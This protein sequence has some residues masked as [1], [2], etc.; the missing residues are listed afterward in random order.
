MNNQPL[1]P[2]PLDVGAMALN[3]RHI[4]EASAGTGKTY[5]ITRIFIRLLLVK[6]VE[7]QQILVVTFTKAATEELR[8]R[9][10]EAVNELLTCITETPD[11]IDDQFRQIIEQIPIDEE[12]DDQQRAQLK[13]A[14]VL[15]KS[16]ALDLDEASVFTIH[17]FCQRVIKQTAF[18]RHQSFTPEVIH[19]SRAY[20]LQE[21]QDWFRRHQ[22]E[23]PIVSQ[24][25]QLG[26]LTPNQFVE[27]FY[28]ALIGYNT[29]SVMDIARCSAESESVAIKQQKDLALANLND[30]YQTFF[31]HPQVTTAIT[32]LQTQIASMQATLSAEKADRIAAFEALMDWLALP[33]YDNLVAKTKVK[34]IFGKKLV[35]RFV[36]HFS[37]NTDAKDDLAAFADKYATLSDEAK[38]LCS[39]LKKFDT[40]LA[41]L[42]KKQQENIQFEAL[43]QEVLTWILDIRGR[44]LSNKQQ[45]EVIDHDDTIHSLAEAISQGNQ[46]LINYI[47]THYPFA[48]IDEFQDTDKH[49]YAIFSHCYPQDAT[50]TMLVMIGDPKQAIYGFRGG[51]INTYILAREGAQL[52]SMQHN[53]RSSDAV[54]NGYNCLFYG[55]KVTENSI[56]DIKNR[57]PLAQHDQRLEQKVEADRDSI[58]QDAHIFDPH[59]PY[60]WIYPGKDTQTNKLSDSRKGAIHFQLNEDIWTDTSHHHGKTFKAEQAL[61]VANEIVRL[62]KETKIEDAPV[63]FKDIAILVASKSEAKYIQDALK[64]AEIASVYLSEK[65]DIFGSKEATYLYQA[66]D[67]ILHA[68]QNHKFFRAVSTELF[69]LSVEELHQLTTDMDKFD[70][71]KEQMHELQQIWLNEGVLVLITSLLKSRFKTHRNDVLKERILTNYTHLSELLNAQSNASE[72]AYQL[73]NWFKKQLPLNSAESDVPLEQDENVQRLESDEALVQIVTLHKSKGLEYPIVFI[74]FAGHEPYSPRPNHILRYFDPEQACI[75]VQIGI[76]DTSSAWQMQQDFAEQ[77]RLL[78]VGITRAVHRCYLGIGRQSRYEKTALYHLLIHQGINNPY[79]Q[80]VSLTEH[81][82]ELFYTDF[83]GNDEQVDIAK[84]Q[85]LAIELQ[86]SSFTQSTDQAWQLASFSKIAR[87]H[88]TVDLTEKDRDQ[89]LQLPKPSPADVEEENS[90][91]NLDCRFSIQR[92]ADTGNLLHNILEDH[93]FSKPIQL[94]M[95][96][97][98]VAFYANTHDTLDIQGL[99]TWINAILNT[100]IPEVDKQGSFTL[101][102]LTAQN[103]LKEPEFYFPLDELSAAKISRILKEHRQQNSIAADFPMPYFTMENLNGMMHGFIDLLFI[104]NGRYYV[105]DYKSNYLGDKALD[106]GDAQLTKAILE[107][108]YDLQYIIYCWALDKYLAARIPDY[109]RE[110]DFGG[111]Y[112]FFLRGMSPQFP[113]G[114]GIYSTQLSNTLWQLLEDTL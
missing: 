48:L 99:N 69:G 106:Y 31:N 74:P 44:I 7:V 37:G 19:S 96:N 52:W 50:N 9:I 104:H 41:K 60:P 17:S 25:E 43:Y 59:I 97:P 107:H 65:A 67:G 21:V 68:N 66:L 61:A 101:G 78:Y 3:G 46:G 39:E 87:Q 79:A 92:S 90:E 83:F 100:P 63:K 102:S 51:D 16:A 13:K 108:N 15:L 30:L 94:G 110:R 84:S 93:D 103:T 28:P 88:K 29:L 55:A 23:Q 4:I 49:Q 2:S 34:P 85:Q 95:E 12:V 70:A 73:L 6:Q 82:P 89:S 72:H 1:I 81:A 32:L 47:R 75:K 18:L 24:L 56:L 77:I 10:A 42:E 54:I 76:D 40:E 8:G 26:I 105:A 5:N 27:T 112:Y 22:T 38:S 111:V 62:T 86:A 80:L 20:V 36:G 11:K 71:L 114:S 58:I 33:S 57:L 109:Q 14:A 35:D 113:Q 53:Y 98:H 64:Q 91:F 45:H